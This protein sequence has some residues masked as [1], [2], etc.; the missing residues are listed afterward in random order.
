MSNYSYSNRSL[1]K[2]RR[3]TETANQVLKLGPHEKCTIQTTTWA[4]GTDQILSLLTHNR[5]IKHGNLSQVIISAIQ[6]NIAQQKG[7]TSIEATSS[8]NELRCTAR[9]FFGCPL[10]PACTD[11]AFICSTTWSSGIV[12]LATWNYRSRDTQRLDHIHHILQH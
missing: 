4:R 9:S 8:R 5:N 7:L 2:Q 1:S 3:R 12:D 6:K 10:P 11:K